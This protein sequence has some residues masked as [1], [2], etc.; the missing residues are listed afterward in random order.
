MI[1]FERAGVAPRRLDA[2]LTPLARFR[3]RDVPHV[4]LEV[5]VLVVDPVRM[6]EI[7]RDAH[8]LAPERIADVQPALQVRHDL[9]QGDPTTRSGRLPI[10]RERRDVHRRVGG[11][12]VEERRILP[13]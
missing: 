11:L 7:E 1:S 3:Q 13:G 9:F 12:E 2:E 6:V 8:D 5:E 10:D 4:E